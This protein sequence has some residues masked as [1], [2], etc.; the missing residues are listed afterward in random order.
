MSDAFLDSPS[1][2]SQLLTSNRRAG[3]QVPAFPDASFARTRHHIV[4][5]GS[6][7]LLN[8]DD[9]SVWLTMVVGKV[10]WSLICKV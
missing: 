10:F 8:C 2:T 9:V 1:G 5:T 6:V 3:D 4:L 7:L